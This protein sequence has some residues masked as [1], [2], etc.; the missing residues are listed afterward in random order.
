MIS[1][2]VNLFLMRVFFGGVLRRIFA[3]R[4][5]TL[6]FINDHCSPEAQEKFYAI[7]RIRFAQQ[8]AGK[9]ESYLIGTMVGGVSLL[10]VGYRNA[11]NEA[12]KKEALEMI[13]YAISH[14][15]ALDHFSHRLVR[16]DP[17]SVIGK[18]LIGY[19]KHPIV[20]YR[21][22]KQELKRDKQQGIGDSVR[23]N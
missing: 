8:R 11:P 23:T 17:I 15:E 10:L 18:T 6:S 20:S 3:M 4:E 2:K 19:L 21:A 5:E 9:A 12:A 14:E 22:I 1:T 7:Y 13:E 16:M